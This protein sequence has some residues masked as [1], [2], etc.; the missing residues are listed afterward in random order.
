MTDG[1][2][3]SALQERSQSYEVIPMKANSAVMNHKVYEARCSS[4]ANQC[5]FSDLNG[6]VL[7]CAG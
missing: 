3:I 5:K 4:N 7:T 2:W 1:I 6:V